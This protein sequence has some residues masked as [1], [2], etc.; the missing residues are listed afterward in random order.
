M[1][2]G[3]PE[4]DDALCEALA[5]DLNILVVSPDYRLTPEHPYPL[6]FD[7]C[8]AGLVWLSE[9]AA[10]LG[11]DPHRIAVGGASAGGNLCAAV[12]LAARDRGGPKICFHMP[13]FPM[14]DD[15]SETPSAREMTRALL[16]FSW[17]RERN[18]L[19]WSWYLKDVSGND[20]PIYA[21]PARADDLS[22]MPPAFTLVGQYDPLRDET[23]EYVRKLVTAGVGAEF[24]LYDGAFHGF[25][26]AAGT[27]TREQFMADIESALSRA[28]A[29]PRMAT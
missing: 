17:N 14:I 24:H 5:D 22:G 20:T 16:P 1:A 19:A 6:P 10:A 12:T 9:N 23:I 2:L 21:A 25:E 4:T 27:P 28:I 26:V 7:D 8:Y 18:I 11:I 13:L 29:T 15:R 3:R